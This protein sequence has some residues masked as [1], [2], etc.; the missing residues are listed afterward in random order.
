MSCS[1]SNTAS[2]CSSR[3]SA[4]ND[5]KSAVSCGFIPAV[6][7]S[8]SNS[9]GCVASARATSSRRWSPYERF[10]P[11][12][13]SFLRRPLNSSSSRA[14]S[15]A[16]R[17]SRFTPGVR[18]TAWK[19][20]PLSL[21]CMPTSTFSSA[22]MLWKRRMFWNVRPMPRSVNACGGFPV[23]SSFA[24]H[25]RP[26]VG[27]YTP[28]SM[29]KNV[30]LPAPFGPMSETIALAGT[31]NSTSSTATRPPNSF[32]R[33]SVRSSGSADS[34]TGDLVVVER[35]VVNLGVV[36]L[37]RDTGARYQPLGP[38]EHDDDDDHAE[39]PE[40]VE[41]HVDV[42]VEVTVDP[43]ADIRQALAVEIG[44]ETRTDDDAGNAAHAAEDDHAENEHRD[45]EE[46]VVR[47]R[48]ALV[49]RIERARDTAEERAGRVRPRLRPHEGDAHRRG[50]RL[51]L[52]NRDPC[53]P[54]PRVAQPHR[55][56]DGDQHE[57][58]RGAEEDG[59]EV[60][61]DRVLHR[62]REMC[63]SPVAEAR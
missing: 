33:N 6:G 36:H 37:R 61:G 38:E 10:L 4:T 22:V 14:R 47:E 55:A 30:V 25:T 15:R 57:T 54:E 44:K 40:L 11:S 32:R 2:P 31:L 23:M 58:E 18:R 50:G 35:L 7:S 19:R 42:R 43:R 34:G 59:V 20:F 62:D 3:N 5:V 21:T 27:L 52:A 28:V 8:R 26:F 48:T 29:L 13:A 51:V 12:S 45:L 60:G 39:D 16:S 24:N 41:R 53:A 56:E 46:E 63:G 17:S 1:I 49:R 9:F